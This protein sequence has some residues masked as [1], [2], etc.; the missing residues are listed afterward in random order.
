MSKKFWTNGINPLLS[1]R[2]K[3]FLNN[4]FT[5]WAKSVTQPSISV[6]QTEF[7]LINHKIK[8]PG[9]VTWTDI[10]IVFVEVGEKGKDLYKKIKQAGYSFTGGSDGIKKK[11]LNS[12]RIEKF[13][14]GATKA[15]AAETWT[16]INPMIKEIK[17]S[18]LD[19]S[20]DDLVTTTLTV[21]YD[22]AKLE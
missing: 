16:L 1:S 3:V 5:F 17:F 6:S 4:D 21:A 22:S 14:S 20:T 8:I 10:D 19:Y 7:Q 12:I 11:N 2:F 18:D 15:Q 13:V 9:I